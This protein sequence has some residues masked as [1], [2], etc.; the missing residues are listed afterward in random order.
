MWEGGR[1]GRRV[2]G[3]RGKW[4]IVS[5]GREGGLGAVKGGKEGGEGRREGRG[6]RVGGEGGVEGGG[7]REEREVKY[8]KCPGVTSNE[9]RLSPLPHPS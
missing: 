1:E 2:G 7:G 9:H 6:K 4:S 3:K 5:G 8:K